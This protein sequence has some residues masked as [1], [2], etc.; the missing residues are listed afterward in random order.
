MDTENPAPS[1]SELVRIADCLLDESGED[2]D[3]LMH[4]LEILPGR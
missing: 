3:A 4:R 2:E 1:F